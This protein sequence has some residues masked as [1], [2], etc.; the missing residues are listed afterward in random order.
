MIFLLL[1]AAVAIGLAFGVEAL[2]VAYAPTPLAAGTK[3][4]VEATRPVSQG[5]NFMPRSEY[6]KI[7]V[8]AA[9]AASPADILTAYEAIYG[10]IQAG[11]KIFIRCTPIGST[12][13]KGTPFYSSVIVA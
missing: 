9:A 11:Q 7:M 5:I 1:V 12:G 3:L 13:F 4:L 8:T 2:S 6:K 10:D